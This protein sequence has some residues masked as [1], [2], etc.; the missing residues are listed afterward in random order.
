MFKKIEHSGK[1]AEKELLE[2]S[3]S[4]ENIIYRNEKNQYSVLEIQSGDEIITAV[5]TFPYISAGEELKMF[6]A[7]TSHPS[8][9]TQFKAEAFEKTAPKTT[10]AILKYLSGGAVKGIGPA[11]AAKIV[12][13]FGEGTLDV[14]ENDSERLAQ[15]RGI[16]KAK[17]KEISEEFKKVY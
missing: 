10:A 8:F 5:G 6:G 11:I 14:L 1:M 2:L 7:W 13:A 17:A 3:G 16:S 4:V 15:I 9:G 12:G